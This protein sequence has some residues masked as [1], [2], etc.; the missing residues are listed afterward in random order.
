MFILLLTNVVFNLPTSV[1][2]CFTGRDEIAKKDH[3]DLETMKMI[4]Y[5]YVSNVK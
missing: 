5:Q 1:N 2:G 3:T 4:K